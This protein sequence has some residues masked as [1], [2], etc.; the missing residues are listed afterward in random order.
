MDAKQTLNEFVEVIDKKLDNY[1]QTEIRKDFGFSQKQKEL[2]KK[3]LLHSQEH[4]LR[5]AKR[6][7]GS[8]VYYGYQLGKP[9]DERIWDAAMGVELIHTALLMHDDVMDQDNVRRGKPTTHKYFENGDPHYGESMAYTLG[10]IVLTIGYELVLSSKFE[11]EIVNKATIKLL[12]GITNTAHGQAYDVSLEKMVNT[13]EEEDVIV[14]HKAKTA[15]YTYENPLYIGAILAGLGDD[16]LKILT[17]YSMDGGVAFQLQDDILGVYGDPEKTGKSANS[18]LL[19]GKVTLLILKTLT[20]GNEQQIHALKKVWGKR[21][22]STDDIEAAKKAIVDSGSLEYSRIVS[23]DF[24]TKA[25]RTAEKLRSL[26]LNTE[27]IDFIQ[28]IAEYMVN[29]DV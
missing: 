3:M 22:A 24:A 19:Q 7:R 21:T 12:R 27:A 11:P 8:F 26:N 28:G 14:L 5:A 18:D 13:W 9:V 20:N 17:D 2:V 1:W 15:I 29:R 6:I 10:D 16:V 25:A 4:N 23:K